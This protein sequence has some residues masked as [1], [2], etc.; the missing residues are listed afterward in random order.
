MLTPEEFSRYLDVAKAAGVQSFSIG[1]LKVT[2][3]DVPFIVTPEEATTPE[4]RVARA[5]TTAGV[6]T[7]AMQ[8]AIEKVVSEKGDKSDLEDLFEHVGGIPELME[9]EDDV[10]DPAE[11]PKGEVHV[12]G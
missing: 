12:A 5:L 6:D 7:E 4:P 9:D 10:I 3:P 11:Y 1:E 2:F 8:D